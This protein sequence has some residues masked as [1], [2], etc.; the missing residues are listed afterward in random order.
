MP[1]RAAMMRTLPPGSLF[2]MFIVWRGAGIAVPIIGFASLVAT[3][4]SVNA[5]G[6][7]RYWNEHAWPLHVSIALT[8]G[9]LWFWGRRLNGR[10]PTV[11][12]TAAHGIRLKHYAAKHSFF[13]LPMQWWGLATGV[14]LAAGIVHDIVKATA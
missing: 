5:A 10:P 11:H 1:R 6:G 13:Y 9:I 3:Q 7:E 12:A 14:L 8:A 2:F 4:L